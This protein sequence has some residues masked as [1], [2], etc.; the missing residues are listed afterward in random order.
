MSCCM[1][2]IEEG[3]RADRTEAQRAAEFQTALDAVVVLRARVAEL[4]S[5]I[6]DVDGCFDTLWLHFNDGDGAKLD[7]LQKRIADYSDLSG[8]G[9]PKRA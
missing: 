7:A 1:H 2:A 3:Q 9:G 4:E 5:I 6:R 8:S